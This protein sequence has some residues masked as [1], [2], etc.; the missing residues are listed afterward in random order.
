[1][2]NVKEIWFDC[3]TYVEHVEGITKRYT[4]QLFFLISSSK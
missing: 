3:G 2:M 1:M 4:L